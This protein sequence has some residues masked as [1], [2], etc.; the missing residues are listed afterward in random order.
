MPSDI[1]LLGYADDVAETIIAS[2]E[3]SKKP[4][5]SLTW[6]G[7]EPATEKTEQV[8]LTRRYKGTFNAIQKMD[9]DGKKIK[10]TE[11]IEY[12]LALCWIQR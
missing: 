11:A 8:F 10:M 4:S 1:Y 2:Q 3:I 6:R 5:A 7:L 12:L 9:V